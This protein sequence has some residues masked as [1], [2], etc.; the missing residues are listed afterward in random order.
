MLLELELS[1]TWLNDSDNLDDFVIN[2][3]QRLFVRNRVGLGGDVL[4]WVSDNIAVQRRS[5]LEVNKIEAMWLEIREN[6]HKFLMCVAYRP[7]SCTNFWIHIQS[8]LD[9][10]H[11][12]GDGNQKVL[13][14]EILIQISIPNKANI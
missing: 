9:N 12:N 13:L 5:D 1:E 3:F 4:C 8:C 7:P 6:V 14:M 2:G 10:V 11:T